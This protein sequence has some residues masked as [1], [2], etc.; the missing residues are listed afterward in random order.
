MGQL[1][2]FSRMDLAGMRDRAG[3]RNY[4]PACDAF[5]REH[6][7]R[8]LW[9]L[10]RRHAEKLR[11]VG[12]A[13]LTAPAGRGDLTCPAITA[14]PAVGSAPLPVT[15]VSASP[16]AEPISP[17]LTPAPAPS[18]ADSTSP[19]AVPAPPTADST[20]PPAPA[21]PTADPAPA[22]AALAPNSGLHLTTRP[23]PTNSRPRP[24]TRRPRPANGRP[25]RTTRRP[26][27]TNG[28]AGVRTSRC[29][30][31]F[32]NGGLDLTA[33]GAGLANNGLG[34][35]SGCAT[36]VGIPCS[37]GRL[38]PPGRRLRAGDACRFRLGGARQ[39]RIRGVHRFRP[40]GGARERLQLRRGQPHR[41]LWAHHLSRAR[42]L[43]R[44]Q[45][46]APPGADFPE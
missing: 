38:H 46:P 30:S 8:R 28:K 37:R 1:S 36:P 44:R 16:V 31:R 22:P 21:S 20:S 26:R 40:R 5:R 27:P 29:G 23:Y 35:S 3:S 19:P 24:T 2:L 4:S 39:F 9:G 18:P 15:P 41:S 11:R 10:R 34:V 7:R 45:M 33:A 13:P 6:E 32:T 25:R 17:S 14:S 42:F 12:T 43:A